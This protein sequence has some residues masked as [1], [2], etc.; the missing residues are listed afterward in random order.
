LSVQRTYTDPFHDHLPSLRRR[1]LRAFTG[2]VDCASLTKNTYTEINQIRRPGKG[3]NDKRTE[4]KPEVGEPVGPYLRG[5][6]I[7]QRVPCMLE[8]GSEICSVA[9]YPFET[10]AEGVP[11]VR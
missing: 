4:K 11:K 8:T 5:C 3:E 7:F 9:R 6:S 1:Y 2:P 10:K